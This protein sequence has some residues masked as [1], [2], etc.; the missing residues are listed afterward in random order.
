MAP[1]ILWP[2]AAEGATDPALLAAAA[3][4]LAVGRWSGSVL[5]ALAAGGAVLAAGLA[6]GG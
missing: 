6:L 2:K 1:A 3:V 5:G 4:T